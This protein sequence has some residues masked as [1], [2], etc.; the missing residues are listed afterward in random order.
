MKSRSSS[1]STP[2]LLLLLGA[3]AGTALA[4]DPADAPAASWVVRG[5]ILESSDLNF[6]VTAPQAWTWAEDTNARKPEADQYSFV[7]RADSRTFFASS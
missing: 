6:Q 1:Y 5:G 3:A 2:I 7:A 4:A